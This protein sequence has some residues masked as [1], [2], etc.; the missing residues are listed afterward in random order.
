MSQTQETHTSINDANQSNSLFVNSFND[1]SLFEDSLNTTIS[2]NISPTIRQ[3]LQP[4][5]DELSS[6]L[7][8]LND[9]TYT[10]ELKCTLNDRISH[11]RSVIDQNN[12]ELKDEGTTGLL[13][14]SYINKKRTFN[15][16]TM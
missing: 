16:R 15:T 13:N 3:E 1:N 10:H 14:G 11:Y 9:K 4:F 7:E 5:F 6:V 2:H 8:S 12:D